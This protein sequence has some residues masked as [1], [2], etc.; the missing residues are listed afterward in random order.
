MADDSYRGKRESF[1]TDSELYC[2]SLFKMRTEER[3]NRLPDLMTDH[4]KKEYRPEIAM[5]CKS[6]KYGG[7]LLA[8]QFA[9]AISTKKQYEK[10]LGES[11][12][13][14]EGWIGEE[15]P[16][17]ETPYHLF[18]NTI[19][20][21]DDLGCVDLDRHFSA[22][23]MRWGDQYIIP[24]EIFKAV[25]LA[26]MKDK[27]GVNL[28]D[29]WNYLREWTKKRI[30]QESSL[31]KD[32]NRRKKDFQN[33]EMIYSISM[34]EKA[35]T[36]LARTD[37]QKRVIGDIYAQIPDLDSY[38]RKTFK[39]PC[40]T[41]VNV[42]V[43]KGMGK[44][45]TQIGES[46]EERREILTTIAN[47]REAAVEML[48]HIKPLGEGEGLPFC[49]GTKQNE[50]REVLRK[51]LRKDLSKKSISLLERL[52]KWKT[53]EDVAKEVELALPF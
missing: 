20:R 53:E 51:I 50:D 26:R 33:F 44:I 4:L 19:N 29:G 30:A 52:V 32:R 37:L 8:E 21:L 46:I 48:S 34:Y 13:N 16:F 40:K 2:A 3:G 35:G 10:I 28:E 7:K 22:I 23:K 9:Y 11:A 36:S 43:P 31:S 17:R 25:Y 12:D 49:N 1:G 27:D 41:N 18:F 24:F 14:I 47:D 42:I 38:P 15:S 45:L 5:E 39:G 6:G